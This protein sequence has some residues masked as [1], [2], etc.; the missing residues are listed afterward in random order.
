MWSIRDFTLASSDAADADRLGK[1]LQVA[2]WTSIAAGE[3]STRTA[4]S[5]SMQ[6]EIADA[7]VPVQGEDR[8][9]LGVVRLSLFS[10]VRSESWQQPIIGDAGQLSFGCRECTLTTEPK[11]IPPYTAYEAQTRM[12]VA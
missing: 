5:Q 7:F 12:A 4:Y 6:D 3:P 10:T 2:D 1:P 8:R 11:S 9:L